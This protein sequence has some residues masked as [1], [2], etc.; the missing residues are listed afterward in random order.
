MKALI[1]VYGHLDIVEI[2]GI[3]QS[4]YQYCY[5]ND[6]SELFYT[7]EQF[8]ADVDKGEQSRYDVPF[9]NCI[10]VVT[11]NELLDYIISDKEM[12]DDVYKSALQELYEN[13]KV[14]LSKYTCIP[15][16]EFSR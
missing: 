15:A 5:K 4:S 2:K 14:D 10:I 7:C 11:A 6:E 13:D 8:N 1:S 12:P 3:I 9:Y 16:K